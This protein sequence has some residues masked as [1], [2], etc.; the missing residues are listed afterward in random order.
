MKAVNTY[1]SETA[2]KEGVAAKVTTSLNLDCPEAIILKKITGLTLESKLVFRG[3]IRNLTSFTLE[4][5]LDPIEIAENL[6][7][8]QPRL[9]LNIHKY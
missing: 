1:A 5:E 6:I 2:W 9:V 3:Q 7:I 4:L 8:P